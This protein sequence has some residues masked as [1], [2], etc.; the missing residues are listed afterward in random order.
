VNPKQNKFPH[1]QDIEVL[2]EEQRVSH[3]NLNNETG[4]DSALIQM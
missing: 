1:F 3:F 4:Q 2:Y